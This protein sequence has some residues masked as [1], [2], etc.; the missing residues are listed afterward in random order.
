MISVDAGCI[1]LAVDVANGPANDKHPL[2]SLVG[3]LTNPAVL[4]LLSETIDALAHS[5]NADLVLQ[6]PGLKKA[7]R[8]CG[9]NDE[10]TADFGNLDDLGSAYTDVIREFAVKPLAGV[11]FTL[12]EVCSEDELDAF[13]PVTAAAGHCDWLV[14]A[15]FRHEGKAA[16]DNLVGQI[17]LLPEESNPPSV[18]DGLIKIGGGLSAKF[19]SGSTAAGTFNL[20]YGRIPGAAVPETVLAQRHSLT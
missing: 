2:A 14:S 7:L 20:L 9:A 6:L 8:A 11:L 15:E 5:A 3:K 4:A 1:L 12:D 16:I 19:W 18:A 13:G 17:I 10:A